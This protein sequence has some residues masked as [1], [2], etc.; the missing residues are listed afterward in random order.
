[1]CV[2]VTNVAHPVI[3]VYTASQLVVHGPQR[4]FSFST[5]ETGY[6]ILRFLVLTSIP[7]PDENLKY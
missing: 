6:T 3:S 5:W 1:M 2:C 7:I 4:I